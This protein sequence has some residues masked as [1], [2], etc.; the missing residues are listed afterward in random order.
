MEESTIKTSACARCP[1]CTQPGSPLYSDLRDRLFDVPGV[2]NYRECSNRQCKLLWLDPMP[3]EEDIGQLYK[4]YFTHNQ[5]PRRPSSRLRQ[6]YGRAT[7]SYLAERYGYG[8]ADDRLL[9]RILQGLL[10]MWPSHIPQIDVRV[11]YQ[12][13]RVGGRL[14]DVGCGNGMTMD[15]MQKLGW[16]CEGVDF[17]PLAVQAAVARGLRVSL[18]PPEA[19]AYPDDTF[20]A[21]ILSHVIE[22]VP[23]PEK[24]LRE[25]CRILRPGGLLT[26]LTPN[27]SALGRRVFGESWL[28]LDPPR[29]LHVFTPPALREIVT[30]VDR[31]RPRVTTTVRGTCWMVQGSRSIRESGR[32]AA[33]STLRR[34][35]RMIGECAE[36]LEWCYLMGNPHGGEEIVV[37]A[38][39]A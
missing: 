34:R 33:D 31:M 35:Q 7:K 1:V 2:W 20:D 10:Y 36:F 27:A 5:P 6:A 26:V 32:F 15:A 12:P 30:R 13:R 14:L 8:G 23:H 19:Q 21:M 11:M 37:L 39:K 16:Q 3:A 4:S 29:H 38:E 18:G 9:N 22:H 28:Y 24:F 25:C 17:D